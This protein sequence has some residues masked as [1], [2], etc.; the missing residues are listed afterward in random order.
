MVATLLAVLALAP[1]ADAD[2]GELA[3]A[4]ARANEAAAELAR[5]ESALGE[6]DA[7]ISS[8]EVRINDAEARLNALRTAVQEHA[9]RQF[10]T[11]EVTQYASYVEGDIN[12]QARAETL[13]RAATRG[14][15]DAVE[16]FTALSEDLA[17]AREGLAER[18]QAQEQA[19][20]E[21]TRRREQLQTELRRLEELERRRVEEERRKAAEAA[22]AEAARKEA[23]RRRTANQPSA[24]APATPIVTGSFVCP[25]QGA[26]AFVDSWGSPRSGGRRHK[27]VDMMAATGTP[28]VAPVSGHVTHRGNGIGG[29][30][31]HLQGDDGNY[32]Y[33]THLSA[34][35]NVGAGHVQAGTVIGYVGSTGNASTPHLHFEVHVGGRGN[36]VNPYPY[37]ARVC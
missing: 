28:T 21:L 5:A 23:E 30:S 10:V 16:E 14:N 29:L 9:V 7:E 26:V 2:A 12:T 18:K 37:V 24:P 11:M 36:A 32:Y 17:V 20:A 27:G 4:R 35:A 22:R 13:G 3:R 19:I 34:Y 6:L 25:V 1:R 33:G 8:L 15:Q 31:W